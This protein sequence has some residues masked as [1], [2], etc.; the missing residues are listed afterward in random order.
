MDTLLRLARAPYIYILSDDDIVFENSL[1][2]MKN[3]LDQHPTIVAVS[4]TYRHST[5]LTV[6]HNISFDQV[7]AFTIRRGE[8][9]S[10]ADNILV[11]D[12]HPLMRRDIFQRHCSYTDRGFGLLPLFGRLLHYG[13]LCFIDQ[14]VFEHFENANSL[15]TS[16]SEYWF[17]DFC[18]SDIEIAF[19]NA[20][21]EFPQVKLESVR[22][23]FLKIIYLLSARMC[24]IKGDLGIMWHFLKRAKAV[25]GVDEVCLVRCEREFLVEIAMRRIIEIANNL[26]VRSVVV[27]STP[28]MGNVKTR[29]QQMAL[30]FEWV[31]LGSN[32][33]EIRADLY[34]VETFNTSRVSKFNAKSAIAFVD[35]IDAMRLT[36]IP[37]SVSGHSV[38]LH[39]ESTH[40]L[41]IAS[42][43]QISPSY[44]TLMSDYG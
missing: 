9:D 27:E 36:N 32:D 8:F 44:S 38:Q 20:Y 11:C 34:L 37:V 22:T 16:T 2:L 19:A 5:K 42:Q 26:N 29:L 30:N 7:K 10:L 1:A 17:Q 12:G 4:G 24:R 3:I 25:G 31:S 33:R 21:V 13:D 35:I 39:I 15:T 28:L 18:N 40:P 6:G 23:N 43:N 14:P 41:M